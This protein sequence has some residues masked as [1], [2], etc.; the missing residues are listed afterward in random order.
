M[1]FGPKYWWQDPTMFPEAKNESLARYNTKREEEL[2]LTVLP[3]P[4]HWEH[5]VCILNGPVCIYICGQHTT[6]G[7]A[8]L[9]KQAN[10]K[11]NT[12]WT[13]R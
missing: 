13:Q 1:V 8:W 7:V 9:S 3:E 2:T 4:P 12:N 6:N 10:T 11:I 5:V